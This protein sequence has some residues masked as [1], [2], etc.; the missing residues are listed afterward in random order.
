MKENSPY[1]DV[2]HGKL[3]PIDPT[4]LLPHSALLPGP[5][6]WRE[7]FAKCS[8]GHIKGRK[9]LPGEISI[10]FKHASLNSLFKRE[11]EGGRE[12]KRV[13]ERERVCVIPSCHYTLNCME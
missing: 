6:K 7:A 11:R 5:Y 4:S 1:L 9:R 10:P 13:R 12:G 2:C 8:C 3:D